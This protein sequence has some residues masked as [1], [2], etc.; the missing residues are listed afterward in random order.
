MKTAPIAVFSAPRGNGKSSLSGLVAADALRAATRGEEIAL[1]AG[2]VDQGRICFRFARAALGEDGFRYIDSAQRCAATNEATGAKLRVLAASGRTAMGLV[3][4]PL[5]IADE[6]AAWRPSD[7]ALLADAIVTAAGKPGSDMRIVFCGTLA[8][9]PDESH[10]WRAMVAAGTRPG[11]YV[12]LHAGDR[13]RWRDLRHVYAVNPLS[14]ISPTF[15]ETLRRERDEALSDPRLKSRFLS[16]R[17]NVPSADES[18]VLL[19][20][21][22]WER[23]TARPV[24]ARDG[25]PVV[26]IDLG[27]GRAWSAAVAIWPSGRCEALAVAPGVP[28]LSGQERRDRV[29]PGTYARLAESGALRVADALRVPPASALWGAV[30]E[31]WGRPASVTCDRFRLSDLLDA[32][33]GTVPVEPRMTRWST[34]AEDIRALRKLALDGPL[35]CAEG[36]RLLIAASLAQATVKSD[37]AGS[38]RLAKRDPSNNTARDDVAAAL[39]L[40]AGAHVRAAVQPRPDGFCD[41]DDVSDAEIQAALAAERACYAEAAA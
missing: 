11:Y 13:K 23:V 25:A 18:T 8:P 3:R 10:W 21:D 29:S 20:V 4:T 33:A 40:A 37:D 28:D 30:L 5:V 2:S 26:G 15:R 41:L 38:T 1:V 36:S 22:D 27:G 24:P 16:Y 9:A 32:T 12:Q 17:L 35:S 14:R 6:P 7:G 34:A 39:T 19:T 31:G